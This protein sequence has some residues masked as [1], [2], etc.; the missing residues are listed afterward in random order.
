MR[1]T[2][3]DGLVENRA[4]FPKSKYPPA[5]LCYHVVKFVLGNV[6]RVDILERQVEEKRL[7]ERTA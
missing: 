2:E 5:H 7:M 1:T 3:G 6:R 4:I